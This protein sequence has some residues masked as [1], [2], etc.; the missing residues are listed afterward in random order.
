MLTAPTA[1]VSFAGKY[2]NRNYPKIFEDA[3]CGAEAKE[4]WQNAQTMLRDIIKSTQLSA[5]APSSF[6]TLA[7]CCSWMVGLLVFC[8]LCFQP[9]FPLVGAF[10]ALGAEMNLLTFLLCRGHVDREGD[11]WLIPCQQVCR[12]VWPEKN[13]PPPPGG[14]G[15][16]EYERVCAL[17]T[18][19]ASITS[20]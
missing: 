15:R 16:E 4:V 1:L 9:A 14:A 19:Y 7:A 10:F 3:R 12:C 2:P 20:P 5:C 18:S 11:H 17:C 6:I 13:P 8:T